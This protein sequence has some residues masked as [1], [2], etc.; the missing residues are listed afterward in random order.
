M[1]EPW[2]ERIEATQQRSG[3]RMHVCM[4][5]FC[6]CTDCQND[7]ALRRAAVINRSEPQ[8]PKVIGGAS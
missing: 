2:F 7:L 8:A 6:N 1:R 5:A 4:H 3:F